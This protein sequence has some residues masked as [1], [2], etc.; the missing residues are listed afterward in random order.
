MRQRIVVVVGLLIVLAVACTPAPSKVAAA[1]EPSQWSVPDCQWAVSTL[2]WDAQ[3]DAKSALDGRLV[4][5][6]LD[7][8]SGY[9]EWASRWSLAAQAAGRH[10]GADAAATIPSDPTVIAWIGEARDLHQKFGTTL[11]DRQWVGYYTDLI[12]LFQ[13]GTCTPGPHRCE[14]VSVS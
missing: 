8:K 13:T 7:A 14:Y 3:L 9:E 1:T 4:I 10:C 12:A 5:G 6:Q 2:T 11:W